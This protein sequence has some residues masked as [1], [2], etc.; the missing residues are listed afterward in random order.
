VPVGEF[1]HPGNASAEAEKQKI[2]PANLPATARGYFLYIRDIHRD[3]F[4]WRRLPI[5]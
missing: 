4:Q 5:A 2:L 3:G 1:S